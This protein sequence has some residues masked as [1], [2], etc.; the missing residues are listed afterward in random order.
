MTGG[1]LVVSRAKNLLPSFKSYLAGVGFTDIAV[2]SCEK[3]ALNYLLAEI[4]PKLVFIESCFYECATP[5]M[6]GRLLR[7]FPKLKVVAFSVGEF[8]D[9]LAMWFFFHGVMSYVNMRDGFGELRCSLQTILA[10]GASW[11][12]KVQD[13]IDLRREMPDPALDISNRQREVMF[14][15][16]NGFTSAE[17]G[18]KMAICVRT[19]EAHKKALYELFHVRNENELIRVAYCLD[20]LEKE[21]LCFYGGNWVVSP[22]PG[23]VLGNDRR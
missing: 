20:L 12:Q 6:L 1:V 21:D 7:D 18:D 10:G 9:D 13:R 23:K 5:Y 19:V 4:K 11:T 16:G 17:T 8:P 15:M 14:F 22:L 3:D 2:S